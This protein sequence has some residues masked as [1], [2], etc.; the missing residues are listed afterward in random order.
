M[1]SILLNW[2][3]DI[4]RRYDLEN[5]VG[6]LLYRTAMAFRKAL[7]LELRRKTGVTFGQWKILAMLSREDGL[8]QKEIADRCEVEGPTL[9]PIIDKMEKEGIVTRKVDREDRRINRIFLTTKADATW[10]SLVDC[11]MQV[12][13]SSIRGIPEEQIKIMR[14]VLEKISQNLM[15]DFGVD[16]YCTHNAVTSTGNT[17]TTTASTTEQRKKAKS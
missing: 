10:N 17:N 3:L 9:I 8:T 2:W 11:S 15:T 12:R 5:S 1:I 13:K 16:H 4:I 7:D 6:F 14:D